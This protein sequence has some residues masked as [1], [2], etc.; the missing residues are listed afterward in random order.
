MSCGGEPG[1]VAHDVCGAGDVGSGYRGTGSTGGC[2]LLLFRIFNINPFC[3]KDVT[4]IDMN[5][6]TDELNPV[7]HRWIT[8]LG[9]R[10]YQEEC[11]WDFAASFS[12]T[13]GCWS[14]TGMW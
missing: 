3:F 1:G 6:L 8:S 14:G 12:D 13:G 9:S 10:V 4:P 11:S 5:Q 2:Y 7:T